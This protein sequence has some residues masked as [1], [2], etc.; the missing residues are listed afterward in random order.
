MNKLEANPTIHLGVDSFS[1]LFSH[2]SFQK[3]AISPGFLLVFQQEGSLQRLEMEVTPR[4][5]GTGN[6]Y[7]LAD[8]RAASRANDAISAPPPP[9]IPRFGRGHIR[10]EKHTNPCKSN[11]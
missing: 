4:P 8:H 3:P 11:S 6:Q 1:I 9:P 10:I 7:R 5:R 2:R